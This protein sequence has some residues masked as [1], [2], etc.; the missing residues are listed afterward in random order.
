MTAS[1]I[2]APATAHATGPAGPRAA[3][4]EGPG[5]ARPLARAGVAALIGNTPL[6]EILRLNPERGRGVRVL[7]KLEGR[8]PGGSVKDRPALFIIEDAERRG[9]LHAGKTLIDATSGNTGIAYAMLCAARGYSCELVLPGN[10]SEERKRVLRA[11]G[12]TLHLTDPLEGQDGA[13]D[14]A[15]DLVVR[16][17][18]RYF[19]ADQYSNP[20]NPLAHEETTGPEIWRQSRASVTHFVAGLG[21]SGTLMGVGRFLRRVKPDVV[22]AGIEPTGPFHGIEGLKH[23]ATSHVPGVFRP[24]EVD[25]RIG[26]PTERAYDLTTRLAREEGLFVGGS[27]GAALAGALDVAEDAPPGSVVV[28]VFAD[29]GDRYLSTPL[30]AR[31]D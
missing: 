18:L 7:A 11:F 5:A 25:R 8:N 30:F 15:R 19:Y 24:G 29:S 4:V 20:A 9:L 1:G 16:D 13:I 12:A 6:V 31:D 3:G 21:T 28:T 26:V 22:V 17:P 2:G 27:S 14:A 10:V 23:M